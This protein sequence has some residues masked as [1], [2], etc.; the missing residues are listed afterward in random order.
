MK[1]FFFIVLCLFS[2]ASLGALLRFSL[3]SALDGFSFPL[4]ILLANM[5][6]SFLLGFYYS[7]KR[8]HALFTLFFATAF[9]G[10]LTTFSTF[11]HDIFLIV[12][13]HS[14]SYLMP[15][16]RISDPVRTFLQNHAFSAL[17]PY[18]AF[19]NLGLNIVLCLVCVYLGKK[20][21]FIFFREKSAK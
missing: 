12:L 15:Y 5:S 9:L 14:F 13:T 21:G 7:K 17:E 1:K 10:S 8:E 16:V 6:G 3:V 2:G 18:H 4:G 19:L 20:R 11:I